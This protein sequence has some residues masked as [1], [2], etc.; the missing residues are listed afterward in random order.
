METKCLI[1]FLKNTYESSHVFHCFLTWEKAIT[2]LTKNCSEKKSAKFLT[3]LENL[4]QDT[5]EGQNYTFKVICYRS[6]GQKRT[7]ESMG[8]ITKAE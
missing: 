3:S 4:I 8:K 6:K 2:K 1:C 5:V 7:V